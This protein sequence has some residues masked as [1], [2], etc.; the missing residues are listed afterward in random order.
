MSGKQDDEDAVRVTP[1][2]L[3]GIKGDYTLGE[4]LGDGE[5]DIV[6]ASS[7]HSQAFTTHTGRCK[8]HSSLNAPV[9]L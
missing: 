5:Q 8:Q 6:S 2:V 1:R 4:Q 9:T 7:Q 3:Q